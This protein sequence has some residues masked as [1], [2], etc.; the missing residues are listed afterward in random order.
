MAGKA[1]AGKAGFEAIYGLLAVIGGLCV[2]IAILLWVLVQEGGAARLLAE[3]GRE[4]EA[5]VMDLR[6]EETRRVDD[7]GRVRFDVEHFVT[8]RFDTPARRGV[9]VEATVGADRHDALR[10]GDR[11]MIRYA[12]SDP[13]VIEFEAGERAAEAAFLRW[14][15]L[16]LGV[17]A[18]GLGVLAVR[19]YRGAG[20]GGA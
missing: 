17:V 7:Q 3:E 14:V 20:R 10:R 19:Q 1:G 11:I 8:V 12:A 15:A 9:E 2:I 18:A 4:A 13:Q 16:G 5:T 6:R